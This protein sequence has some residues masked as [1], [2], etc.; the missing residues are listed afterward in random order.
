MK[1]VNSISGGK[2][3]AYLAAK[4][5]ADYNIF[6]LVCIDDKR[7]APKDP[8]TIQYVNAKLEAFMPRNN[9]G[10]WRFI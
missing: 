4:Y 8:A 2:T 10:A 3:S 1:T 6:S 9:L 7:S 5:P